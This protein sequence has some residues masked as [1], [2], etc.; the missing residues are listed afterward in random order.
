[1]SGGLIV[2]IGVAAAD[3]STIGG[4]AHSLAQMASAGF[5]VPAAFAIT[6]HAF[7]S[8]TKEL[9]AEILSHFDRLAAEFVAVRSSAIGEDSGTAAWAGQLDTFLNTTRHTL[10][11]NVRR[12]WESI[13]SARAQSYASQKQLSRGAVGVLV[14]KMVQSEV[15][16]VAFSTHPITNNNQHIVIEAGLGLG[17]AIVSG[18]ITP[19]TYITHKPTATVL[20]KHVSRQTTMLAKDTSGNTKWHK[21]GPAGT[22]QKLHDSL[23]MELSRVVAKLEVYFG[24]PV[25]VEWAVQNNKLYILQSR[26][27]TTL[28]NK[29]GPWR[30]TNL[31]S[32]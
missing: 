4:K 10:I 13:D 28:S 5:P 26:P 16:G 12:C 27:I 23:I 24:H 7:L 1:M 22:T 6:T 3:I 11:D 9:E 14:Q 30:M 19:D 2:P 25:D 8:M 15:S 18:Q 32:F 31:Q 20:E 17:E 21:L 29:E